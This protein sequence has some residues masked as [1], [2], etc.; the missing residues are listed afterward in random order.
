[1]SIGQFLFAQLD[2]S[3]IHGL[4]TP[5]ASSGAIS[6]VLSIVFAITGSVAL[7]VIVIAGFR[8]IIARGDPN[9]YLTRTEQ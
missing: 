3:Q 8:Y 2:T 1:M 6:T 9:S 4:P 7:L 5:S